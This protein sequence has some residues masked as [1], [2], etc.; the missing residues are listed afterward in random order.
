MVILLIFALAGWV[1]VYFNR[2]LQFTQWLERKQAP[3][4]NNELLLSTYAFESL[5]ALG[6]MFAVAIAVFPI[7]LVRFAFDL[8]YAATYYSPDPWIVDVGQVFGDEL[9][10]KLTETLVFAFFVGFAPLIFSLITLLIAGLATGVEEARKLGARPA[11][12]SLGEKQVIEKALE[13]LRATAQ[14]KQTAFSEPKAV[15][16]IPDVFP[17]SY[18]VGRIIYLKSGLFKTSYV[19]AVLAHEL[20]HL[21]NRDGRLLLAVRRLVIPLAYWI[22]IDRSQQ[23]I[24][25]L[26]GGRLHK[27]DIGD[28]AALYYKTKTLSTRLNM[29]FWLGGLGLLFKSMQWAD[30][31]KERDFKA[32]SFACKLGEG[33]NLK[34]F[35][36]EYQELDMAQPYLLN[37][38]PYAAERIELLTHELE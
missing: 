11:L 18:T 6:R 37:A 17:G 29:A 25:S 8:N 36:S 20:G 27:V 26:S 16:V 35:L 15:L 31:W 23:P 2:E 10:K 3:L 32:D 33:L 21:T 24:G 34:Q 38:R 4:N 5:G 22:G 14:T 28:D 30:L 19:K 7:Q 9:S 13:E 12:E 1:F